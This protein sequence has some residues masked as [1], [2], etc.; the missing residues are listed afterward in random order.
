[1]PRGALL[2]P[3]AIG[4]EL[5]VEVALRSEAVLLQIRLQLGHENS[6]ATAVDIG[7]GKGLAQQ[8]CDQRTAD[9]PLAVVALV[10]GQRPAVGCVH[11]H[12]HLRCRGARGQLQHLAVASVVG[13]ILSAM[14]VEDRAASQARLQRE[15]VAAAAAVYQLVKHGEHRSQPHAGRNED[16]GARGS[17][18]QS[19]LTAWLTN[20]DDLP[21]L[22]AIVQ[23]AGHEALAVSLHADPVCVRKEA[24]W[25]GERVAA[26]DDDG[27]LVFG[28]CGHVG[29]RR[30]RFCKP[31]GHLDFQRQMLPTAEAGQRTLLG[32]RQDEARDVHTL[33]HL[34]HHS[35]LA[36]VASGRLGRIPAQGQSSIPKV[37]CRVHFEGDQPPCPGDEGD[38]G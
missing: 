5:L 31:C 14:H 28:I 16:N 19:E 26:L 33:L 8:L 20:C 24:R 38:R 25:A 21:Y 18:V 36:N 23:K 6:W 15:A 7:V 1:M 3:M 4:S 22:H 37:D 27:G 32:V 30:D 2:A 29:T 10:P 17:I 13:S 11:A 35:H 9:T 34:L 12:V